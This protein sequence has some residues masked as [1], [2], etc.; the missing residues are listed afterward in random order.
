MCHENITGKP[1]LFCGQNNDFMNNLGHMYG[2]RKKTTA[3]MAILAEPKFIFQSM[4]SEEP[5]IRVSEIFLRRNLKLKVTFTTLIRIFFYYSQ[6]NLHYF[7]WKKTYY[8]S[9]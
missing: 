8:Q 5:T 1:Q 6:F 3:F 7:F 4:I 2:A 9:L